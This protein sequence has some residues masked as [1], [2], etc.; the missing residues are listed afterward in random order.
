MLR[1]IVAGSR[2]ITDPLIVNPVLDQA[3]A[4]YSV[5]EFEV[6]SGMAN[7]PDILGKAW[8]E[9]RLVNV[10]EVPANWDK[11]GK[12]A[13][14]KR[15]GIMADIADALIAFWDGKSSGTKG[16]INT[17]IE[18]GLVTLTIHS[19][20]AVLQTLGESCVYR[21]DEIEPLTIPNRYGRIDDY[22]PLIDAHW[23]E[24]PAVIVV[25]PPKWWPRKE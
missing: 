12:S 20:R 18:K 8:A 24:Q 19:H 1:V 17:A 22:Q 16:M 7:G 6:V 25:P 10:V 5:M 3:L 23:Q 15:N 11:F 14:Y 21:L 2:G 13:G 4:G 9:D